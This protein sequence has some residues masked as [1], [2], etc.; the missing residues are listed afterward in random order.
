MTRSTRLAALAILVLAGCGDAEIDPPVPLYGE[1]P[2]LYPVELWDEGL[3][4]TTVLRVRVTDT[5]VVDSLE[6]SESSG[7]RGLDEA[8][9]AGA[10]DLKFQPGRRN[11]K[12]V[13]MWAS[14]P[15]E[16]STRPRPGTDR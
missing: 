1:D 5:G 8:A 3:E 4:G 12:R 15:V 9:L 2:V 11:G 7:H 6:V 14:L 13:R 16:F 10:R